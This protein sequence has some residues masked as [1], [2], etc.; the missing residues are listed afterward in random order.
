MDVIARLDCDGPAADAISV[1]MSKIL[2]QNWRPCGSSWKKLVGSPTCGA[3]WEGQFEEVLSETWIGK[4]TELGMSVYS[5]K[6]AGREQ[7]MALLWKKLMKETKDDAEARDDYWS[8]EGN[9]IDRF[10]LEPRVQLCVPKEESFSIPLKYID[11]T[12]STHT[13]L[14]VMQEKRIDN[15]RN[16]DV[17]R[18]LSRLMERFHEIYIRDWQKFKRL[19]DQITCGLRYGPRLEKAA[20]NREKQE[21]AIEKPNL[22]NARQVLWRDQNNAHKSGCVA[23]KHES[24]IIG[25]SMWIEYLSHSST[26]FTKLFDFFWE[27]ASKICVVHGAPNKDSSNHRTWLF[28]AFDLEWHDK[29][30][31]KAGKARMGSGE[32]KDRQRSE[33][34]DKTTTGTLQ[35]QMESVGERSVSDQSKPCSGWRI[36]ILANSSRCCCPLWRCTSRLSWKSAY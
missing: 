22:E 28:V 11:V 17:N 3:L 32:T 29:S 33:T 14:D 7:N 8:M 35:N 5:P 18:S 24:T 13:D 27:T 21:W 30:C 9:F 20:Q 12:R 34:E 26:R 23:R 16:V 31:Q 25:M 4:N 19:Q 15:Y 10:H 1:R 36:S 2:G 6:M